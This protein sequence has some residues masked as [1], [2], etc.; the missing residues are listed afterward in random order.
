MQTPSNIQ[1]I[2]NSRPNTSASGIG[3][4][5]MQT[6]LEHDKEETFEERLNSAI[7]PD[8]VSAMDITQAAFTRAHISPSNE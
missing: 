3:P 1:A 7:S 8:R 6:S 5:R 2:F 4:L